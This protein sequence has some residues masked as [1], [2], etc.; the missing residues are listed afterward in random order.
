MTENLDITRIRL[1]IADL[2][3]DIEETIKMYPE[4]LLANDSLKKE[5]I[6]AFIDQMAEVK[7][8]ISIP[9]NDEVISQY[10]IFLVVRIL[11]L[12]KKIKDIQNPNLYQEGWTITE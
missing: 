4:F 2:A 6:K 1:S 8:F 12:R 7:H 3:Y 10:L 5:V 11:E 9:A